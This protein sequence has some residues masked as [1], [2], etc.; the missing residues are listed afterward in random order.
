MDRLSFPDNKDMSL[1]FTY[2]VVVRDNNSFK[3]E[4][5]DESSFPLVA[6]ELDEFESNYIIDFI[7]DK[8]MDKADKIDYLLA[9]SSGLVTGLLD[10]FWA[11]TFSLEKA[12][13]FGKEEIND[14]VLKAARLIGY[15]G[16]SLKEA[17]IELEKKYPIPSDRAK[18]DLGGPLQHH[19]RDFAHHPTIVGLIFSIL[20]QFTGRAYGTDVNGNFEIIPIKNPEGIGDDFLSKVFNASVGWM[21]HLIS[22]MAGSS[23]NPGEGTGI[24]GQIVSLLKEFSALPLIKDINIKYK[25]NPIELSKW[26]SKLYNGG[27]FIDKTERFGGANR[28]DLRA[29]VG[30]FHEILKQGVPVLINECLVRSIYSIRRLFMEIEITDISSIE[31]IGKIDPDHFLPFNNKV[32]SRM[33]IVS[34]GIFLVTDFAGSVIIA[35]KKEICDEEEFRTNFLLGINYIGIGRFVLACKTDAKYLA[36]DIKDA[37]YKFVDDHYERNFEYDDTRTGIKD[38]LLNERQTRVLYAIKLQILLHDVANCGNAVQRD[39]KQKWLEQWKRVILDSLRTRNDYYFVEDEKTIHDLIRIEMEDSLDTNW[40]VLIA[41]ELLCF[42]PYYI[43]EAEDDNRLKGLKLKNNYI[44]KKFESIQSQLDERDIKVLLKTYNRYEKVITKNMTK[45]VAGFVATAA[46]SVATGGVALALA[47][48]IAVLIAGSSFAGLSGAALTSASLAMIGG[49]SLAA[50]G[51]GMAGGTAIIAGGGAL[52]GTFGSATTASVAMI[53][54]K[55]YTL[56]EGSKLLSYCSVIIDKKRQTVKEIQAA[57]ETQ[58]EKMEE[59]LMRLEE[60]LDSMKTKK[61]DFVKALKEGNTSLKYLKRCNDE[62]LRMFN[63][64][65]GIH[66]RGKGE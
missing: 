15:Q 25:N 39:A 3:T 23:S 21:F 45:K 31:D 48:Q 13:S 66:S 49:G 6:V 2:D 20:S 17:I 46:V 26:I 22:D 50:G 16:D 58:I 43:L 29:E 18:N 36:H 30:I 54:S 10:V 24:P 44:V 62:I 32:L 52:I 8:F 33:I 27:F 60:S 55:T 47:P 28:F 40:L 19:L 5:Q 11:G 35:A 4:H 9:A 14:I 38:L 64:E 51:F 7:E 53:S 37:Y 41:L 56:Q 63:R 57:L 59:D 34:S 12:I 61:R 65:E 1:S 42:K